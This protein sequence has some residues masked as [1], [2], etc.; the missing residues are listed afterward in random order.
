MSEQADDNKI[1]SALRREPEQTAFLVKATLV[2]AAVM[3]AWNIGAGMV[4]PV[5]AIT[6]GLVAMLV[7]YGALVTFVVARIMLSSRQ[8]GATAGAS[9]ERLSVSGRRALRTVRSE[10]ERRFGRGASQDAEQDG[11][12]VPLM[13]G[14]QAAE[15][16]VIEPTVF[17]QAYFLLRL[18]EQVKDARRDNREMSVVAV[19]V[20]V[21]GQEIG[22]EMA[23]RIAYEMARIGASQARVI[24]QPLAV[25]DTEYVFTLPHMSA[26]ETKTFVS[27]VVQALGEYWCHFGVAVFPKNAHDAEGLV[28]KAREAC[29]ASRNGGKRGRVEYPASA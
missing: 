3:A 29:E 7:G 25:G 11:E 10:S 15:T 19:D 8:W 6:V 9:N 2:A 20:T 13:A 21:P 27:E 5:V 24:G 12:P 17:N 14:A 22:P 18:Q 16:V 4:L 28:E 1:L 23:D 26:N